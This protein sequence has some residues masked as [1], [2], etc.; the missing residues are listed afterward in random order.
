MNLLKL[1]IAHRGIFDNQTII[2]N[3]LPSFQRAIRYCIP[4]EL[5]VQLTKDHQLVVFHDASLKRMTGL[6][7]YLEDIPVEELKK[8]FLLSTKEKVPTLEDVLK[9]ISGKVPIII[10]LKGNNKDNILAKEVLNTLRSYS[11]EVALQS[12]QPSVV[13]Y[14][15]KNSTYPVGL[16]ITYFPSSKFY[17]YLMS[18]SFLI[19]YCNPDFLAI[20][21]KIITKKRIQGYR[22]KYPFFVWTIDSLDEYLNIFAY[23]DS[24]IC[25]NL[26][27]LM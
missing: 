5:D 23:A 4:I 7:R 18:S 20:N 22:K 13:K 2:E 15:K 11:G 16:L 6:E 10:E 21:K 14:L 24:F 8:Y 27:Y 26:P 17:S 3:S 12:F 25:N 9:L 19:R 1:K